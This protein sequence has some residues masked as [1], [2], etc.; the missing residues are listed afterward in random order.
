M[1]VKIIELSSFEEVKANIEQIKNL[2][3]EE[4]VVAVRGANLTLEEQKIIT[5]EFGEVLN[6]YPR[7]SST[8][9]EVYTENHS[10]LEID[11]SGNDEIVVYWHLE[12]VEYSEPNEII[13]GGVWNM[14]NFQ[15]D[16]EAGKTYF[17]DSSQILK[18]MPESWQNI[19]ENTVLQW[20]ENSPIP[21]VATHWVTGEKV[22][23]IS[24]NNYNSGT[25]LSFEGREPSPLEVRTIE[26]IR[27]YYINEVK[28]NLEIRRVHKWQQ[29][30]IIFTDLFKNVH[31]VTGGFSPKNRKFHG[32]W[33]YA[34]DVEKHHDMA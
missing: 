34:V 10:R 3:L 30:D 7:K 32:M 15:E 5:K 25:V 22:L 28:N 27:A 17:V 19:M 16:P 29:G 8:F 14:V 2:F 11:G 20:K 21:S 9:E 23:R 24:M 13:V 6:A 12:H 18:Q 33:M 26:K 1:D 31:A 4:T